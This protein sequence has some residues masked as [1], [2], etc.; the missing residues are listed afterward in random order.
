MSNVVKQQNFM[1]TKLNDF[2]VSCSMKQCWFLVSASEVHGS[3]VVL[4]YKTERD[5][6]VE[7]RVERKITVTTDDDDG[8]DHDAVSRIT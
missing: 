6:V 8:I 7:T 4:Q 5:G 1:P 3:M 2:T